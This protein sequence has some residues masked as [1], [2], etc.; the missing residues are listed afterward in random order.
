M[1]PAYVEYFFGSARIDELCQDF[2]AVVFGVLDLAVELA[3]RESTGSPFPELRV[4]FC[5]EHALPP[6][7]ER[8]FRAL[9][10]HFA[11]LE[12]QRAEARLR[13]YQSC[14]QSGGSHAND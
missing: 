5:V 9:S 13:Q 7:P 14:E 3:V 1:R 10:N 12:D 11:A 6:E 8:V 4:G 2:S